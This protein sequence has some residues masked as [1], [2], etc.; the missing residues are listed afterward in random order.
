MEEDLLGAL[1]RRNVIFRQCA[2][3]VQRGDD[4][5]E[6]EER[7][8]GWGEVFFVCFFPPSVWVR[9]PLKGR[10]QQKC[11]NVPE[12]QMAWHCCWVYGW[13]SL[14]CTSHT[15]PSPLNYL[16]PYRQGDLEEGGRGES[17]EGDGQAQMEGGV[18]QKERKR[19]DGALKCDG[20][21]WRHGCKG[22]GEA[23]KA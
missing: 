21:M 8:G 6:E 14:Y 18:K 7:W 10:P 23:G 12:L 19:L 1:D 16:L 2:C 4:E 20:I 3:T 15:V 9:L 11:E 13:H 5:E 22:G 17:A